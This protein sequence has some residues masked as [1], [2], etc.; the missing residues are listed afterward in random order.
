MIDYLTNIR[1]R[2]NETDRMGYLHHSYYA[3]YLEIARTEMLRSLGVSYKQ[4]EENGILLPVY[5]LT[6]DYKKPAFYDDVL[7]IKILMKECPKV[8]LELD[9]EIYKD[10]DLICKANTIN[11]FVDSITRKPIKI[12]ENLYNL[13]SKYFNV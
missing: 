6:I 11:V 7:L 5:K 10:E 1:V 8:K 2:Y 4:L 13:F 3:V 9:Y 12:P